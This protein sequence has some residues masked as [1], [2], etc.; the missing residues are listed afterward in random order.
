MPGPKVVKIVKFSK[1]GN[2]RPQIKKVTV[3][4]N[5]RVTAG[6]ALKRARQRKASIKKTTP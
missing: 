3:V 2:H 5:M 4:G 6:G 1:S